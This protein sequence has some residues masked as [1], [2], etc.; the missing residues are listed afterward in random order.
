MTSH[1]KQPTWTSLV[2]EALRAQDDFLT[3]SDIR[4]SVPGSNK[5]QI[6]AALHELRQYR[7]VDVIIQPDGKGWWFALPADSDTR[8]RTLEERALE[9]RPRRSRKPRTVKKEPLS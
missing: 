8:S 9:S 4:A 3:F 7:A 2:L 6:S 5:N 1:H